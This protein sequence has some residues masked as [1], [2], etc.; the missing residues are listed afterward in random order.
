MGGNRIG[1]SGFQKFL[2]LSDVGGDA[3][4][5][6]ILAWKTGWFGDSNLDA[7]GERIFGIKIENSDEV[8]LKH[9]LAIQ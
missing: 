6:W 3:A 8:G 4:V 2:R 1:G 5:T 7:H 9:S